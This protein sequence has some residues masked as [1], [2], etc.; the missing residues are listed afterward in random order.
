MSATTMTATQA[1]TAPGLDRVTLWLLLAFVASLQISIG[2][3]SILLTAMLLSWAV[4]L[5]RERI[6]PAAPRFFLPLVVYA[7][8]TLVS[9]VFSLD[10]WESLL[11]GKHLLLFLFVPAVYQIARPHLAGPRHAGARRRPGGQPGAQRVG[12][13]VRRR[14]PAPRAQG[15]PLDRAAADRHRRGVRPGAGQR[16]QPD[17]HDVRRRGPDQPGS[18]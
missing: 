17:D 13:G 4:L 12:R 5:V 2:V 6:R 9:S 8:A 10:P 14:R 1:R 7:I 3:A 15:L 18:P 16:H 11:D